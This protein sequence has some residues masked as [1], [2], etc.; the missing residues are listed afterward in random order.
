MN[1]HQSPTL[2]SG[3]RSSQLDQ[4][5]HGFWLFRY[6]LARLPF[7][8]M[9]LIHHSWAAWMIDGNYHYKFILVCSSMPL[10]MVFAVLP[11]VRDCGWPWWVALTTIIPY[12]GTVTGFGL[13]FVRTKVFL[14]KDDSDTSK[15]AANDTNRSSERVNAIGSCQPHQLKPKASLP[16]CGRVETFST[17]TISTNVLPR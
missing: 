2:A 7:A 12:L 11:R 17:E 10:L 16:R 14:L 6:R 15:N 1:P 9:L 8:I 4:S 13:L 3:H 5:W